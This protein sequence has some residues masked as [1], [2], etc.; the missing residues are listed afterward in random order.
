VEIGRIL[1]GGENGEECYSYEGIPLHIALLK[2]GI[3][4]VESKRTELYTDAPGLGTFLAGSLKGVPALLEPD[5][6]NWLVSR[7]DFSH[8]APA[9][10]LFPSHSQSFTA[11][12]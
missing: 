4:M 12:F 8:T 7:D 1:R 5:S 9:H 3:S 11:V 2:S 10:P 6:C